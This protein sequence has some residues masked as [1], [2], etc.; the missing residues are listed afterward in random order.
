MMRAPYGIAIIKIRSKRTK[1][2][3]SFCHFSTGFQVSPQ[4]L[5]CTLRFLADPINVVYVSHP[6]YFVVS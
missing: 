6:G 2:G 3:V 1:V 4:K 5:E